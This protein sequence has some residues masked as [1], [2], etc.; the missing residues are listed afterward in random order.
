MRTRFSINIVDSVS[1]ETLIHNLPH[2]DGRTTFKR[3]MYVNNQHEIGGFSISL[4]P[5]E[6][7]P[8]VRHLYEQLK[9]WQRVEMYRKSGEIE[10]GKDQT[11]NPAL[12]F[13][14]NDYVSI[15][16]APA[17]EIS[18]SFAVV[19][20]VYPA[21]V[22]GAFQTI[23]TKGGTGEAESENLNYT[24]YLDGQLNIVLM[25][26]TGSGTNREH[27]AAVGLK[28]NN[29]YRV[30]G[31]YNHR[32]NECSIYLNGE[33]VFH[34]DTE[35]NAPVSNT[36]DARIGIDNDNSSFPFYGKIS[37]VELYSRYID[38]YEADEMMYGRRSTTDLDVEFSMNEGLGSTII[39][40]RGGAVGTINGASWTVAPDPPVVMRDEP[41]FTGYIRNLPSSVNSWELSGIDAFG[42]LSVRK[43]LPIEEAF[44]GNVSEI[45]K[46]CLYARELGLHEK[47]YAA[48]NWV[49]NGAGVGIDSTNGGIKLPVQQVSSG[50]KKATYS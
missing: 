14:S 18:D 50:L 4:L 39:D 48:T 27:V 31:S 19:A 15:P 8:D 3:T 1:G 37:R 46:R 33:R 6:A 49:L 9:E 16:N 20:D 30:I 24:L 29:W 45:V 11:T 17:M 21:R 13:S 7:N 42:R 22:N 36:Q 10:A 23:F 12:S 28:P 25:W 38:L 40:S 32:T 43:C 35:I 2:Q 47:P 41:V 34:T 5:V 26:E 44:S